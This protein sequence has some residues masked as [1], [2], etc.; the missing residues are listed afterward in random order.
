[1]SELSEDWLEF[2]ED[3]EKAMK[4][5]K[6][7]YK[8]FVVVTKSGYVCANDFKYYDKFGEDEH[9]YLFYLN[10]FVSG[11]YEIELIIGIEK[12]IQRCIKANQANKNNSKKVVHPR[13]PLS[14]PYEMH[15]LPLEW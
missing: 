13:S 9:V 11:I 2:K 8:Y 5:I 6:K 15:R 7:K 1:M 3:I 14:H 4:R 10:G 12:D